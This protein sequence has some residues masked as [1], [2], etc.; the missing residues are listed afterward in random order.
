M[1]QE[2]ALLRALPGT[3]K[4]FDFTGKWVNEL[5][6]TVTIFQTDT[7]LKG[8]YDSAVS[9]GGQ[10][11]H[12]DLLGYVDGDLISFVVHWDK[13]QSITAWVG[14]VVPT[15]SATTFKTL[16]QMTSQV[17]DGEEWMS[18]SAGADTFKRQ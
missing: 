15:A 13:Y 11:T 7:V 4:P 12:G 14:Q 18:I 5:N 9:A 16:W 8:S 3:E 10:S 17:D 2:Q 6:S 1:S